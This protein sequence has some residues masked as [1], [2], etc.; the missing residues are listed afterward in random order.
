MTTANINVRQILLK[1]GNTARSLTYTGPIGEITLDTDLNSIRVHNGITAGGVN[2]LATKAQI[3]TLS[4]SISTI[5]GIDASFVANINTLLSNAASQQSS[6]NDISSTLVD[7]ETAVAAIFDGTAQFG[8]LIP[9]ANVTYNLGS[10]EFQWGNLYVS[11]DTIYIAGIPLRVD[12]GGNLTINGN[13][14]GGGVLS[15][16]QLFNGEFTATLDNEGHLVANQ[17]IA[18]RGTDNG[19]GYSFFNDGGYDT[20]MFSAEDGS[21]EFHNNAIQSATADHWGNW[22]FN[23]PVGISNVYNLAGVT[24]QN[25]DLSHGAT[26]AVIL[27][28]NGSDSSVQ[29]NNTY[30]SI[31]VQAGIDSDLTATWTFA[32]NGQITIPQGGAIGDTYS[33]GN[34]IGVSAGPGEDDYAVINS[35][36]GAQY[37]ETNETAVYIGTNWPT[38]NTTWTFNK[39]GNVSLP[40]GYRIGGGDAGRGIEL[41]TDRGTILFGNRPEPGAPS[42]F[43]IMKDNAAGVDLY[44]G[45][46]FN[47]VKLPGVD[48]PNY[49]V[50]IGSSDIGNNGPEYKWRFET[51]GKLTFPDGTV[52]TTAYVNNN[53]NM[54]GGG[55]ST[56]YEIET[57]YADGGFASIR[58]FSETFDGNEGNN[59]ILDGGR[60]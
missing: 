24:V 41:S 50:E 8:N 56:V 58:S 40:N 21:L 51:S 17:F 6:I 4:N 28:A 27:P 30:G 26:A 33:D 59:Y 5:T 47:Y 15:G 39:D 1:K 14:V 45:D 34:G 43:H 42:H 11:S 22:A 23:N 36:S 32:N 37:V 16:S 46:D 49:G 13:S 55:A 44:F 2:I 60:A 52:Q 48:S 20:G 9:A 12:N 38:T 29:I 31:V 35:H 25:A 19:A 57:A 18:N 7:V 3:D 54:D 53:V 10:P